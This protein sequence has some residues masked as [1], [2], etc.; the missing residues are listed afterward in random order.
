VEALCNL[1]IDDQDKIEA[2]L[3]LIGLAPSLHDLTMTHIF[4]DEPETSRASISYASSHP[5]S[6]NSPSLTLSSTTTSF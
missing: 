1:N 2:L 5:N 4:A 3:K 6:L